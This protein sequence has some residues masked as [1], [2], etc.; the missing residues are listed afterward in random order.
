V[1]VV[2]HLVAIQRQGMSHPP[3]WLAQPPEQRRTMPFFPHFMMRDVLLWLVIF[4]AVAALAVFWPAHLGLEADPFAPAPEGIKPEWY[5]LATYQVLKWLP[6]TIGPVSGELVGVVVMMICGAL[7][8]LVP[9]IDRAP[10]GGPRKRWL[11]VVGVLVL[12]YLIIMTVIGHV[13]H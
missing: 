1:F 9:F 7:V 2:A 13:T 11:D 8:I 10:E 4:N 6:A 12:S 5:F 3:G